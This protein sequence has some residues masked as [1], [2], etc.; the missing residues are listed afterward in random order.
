MTGARP[1]ETDAARPTGVYDTPQ[2]KQVTG[3]EIVAILLSETLFGRFR[4]FAPERW[5]TAS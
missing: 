2:P 5:R 3:I 4:L 1:P